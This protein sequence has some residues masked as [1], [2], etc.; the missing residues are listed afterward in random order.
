[1]SVRE[2]YPEYELT[3]SC[4]LHASARP[5]QLPMLMVACFWGGT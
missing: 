3:S 1:M 5:L 4:D 2:R